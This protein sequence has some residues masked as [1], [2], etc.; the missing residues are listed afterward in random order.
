MFACKLKPG[1]NAFHDI[2]EAEMVQHIL[3]Y[4]IPKVFRNQFI[5]TT[6][7]NDSELAIDSCHVNQHAVAQLGF[8]HVQLMK[9]FS[10]P[11][12]WIFA[13]FLLDANA[14]LPR[15]IA[16]CILYSL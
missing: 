4:I 9:V 2:T 6:I 12:K 10:R 16:L 13:A 7:A 8:V 1:Y 11:V 5:E 15:G 14:Y 3:F